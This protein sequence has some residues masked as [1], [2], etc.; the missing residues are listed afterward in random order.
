[1]TID[2]NLIAQAKRE[3]KLI[4]DQKRY[5]PEDLDLIRQ[6]PKCTLQAARYIDAYSSPAPSGGCEDAFHK[7]RRQETH[8][9][10]INKA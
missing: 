9:M 6:Y 7:L 8:G 2:P 3:L 10:K 4:Q 5:S 1:M